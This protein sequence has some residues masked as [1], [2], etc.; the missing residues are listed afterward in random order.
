MT[1]SGVRAAKT[2][3]LRTAL[4]LVAMLLVAGAWAQDGEDEVSPAGGRAPAAAPIPAE[5][6]PAPPPEP[7]TEQPAQPETTPASPPP[8]EPPPPPGRPAPGRA[9]QPTSPPAERPRPARQELAA[10]QFQRVQ[11]VDALR[12]RVTMEGLPDMQDAQAVE[13]GEFNTDIVLSN[14]RS[15]PWDEILIVLRY[16]PSFL[17]PVTINDGVLSPFLDGTPEASVDRRMGRIV[18]R[19]RLAR[20][21]RDFSEPLLFVRWQALRPVVNTRIRW[22]QDSFGEYTELF[23]EDARQ[24][25]N[26]MTAGDG[27]TSLNLKILP[28]DP[29]EAMLMQEEPSLYLGTDQRVG[30]VQLRI[31]GPEQPVRVGDIFYLDIEFD[32]RAYSMI[33][34]VSLMMDYDPQVI[35]IIDDDWDNWITH[36]L[37]I[38]DGSYRVMFPFDYHMANAVYPTRGMIEYRKGTSIPEN[39]LGIRG[40]MAHIKAR[41][42]A[43]TSGTSVRFLFAQRPGLRGTRVT[44][45]GQNVLG[46]PRR[47]NDGVRGAYFPIYSEGTAQAPN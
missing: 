17:D 21:A 32:N 2:A 27:T 24:L 30:G 23:H 47:P 33:D 4:A 41:A 7:P 29:V 11:N 42:I 16:D 45:M 36:G 31:L 15:Q 22:G 8:G 46:D 12:L 20:P 25:G 13:G 26:P 28:A 35:E 38:H 14:P 10:P 43:P 6:Q 40:T 44:Y 19:A 5:G 3:A 39:L 34:G 1:V 18:Y 9:D 37:N